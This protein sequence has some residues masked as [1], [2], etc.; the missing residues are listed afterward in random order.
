MKITEPKI[1]LIKLVYMLKRSTEDWADKQ[2]CCG[3]QCF[4][5][6]HLPMFM[7][8]GTQGI[9]NNA[10]ASKVNV[11]KQAASKVIKLLEAD[12]LVKSEKSP[13]DARSVMLYLTPTGMQLFEHL[14]SQVTY[15]EGKYQ[16]LVGAENYA[17]A[18]EVM[19]KLV[20]FHDAN[21][22]PVED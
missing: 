2:L 21:K 4:N 12:G 20:E 6:A 19:S 11:T 5:N 22:C 17:I 16:E 8:I 1:P 15:L 7:S 13:N 18:L 9:S 14:K 10:L 3:A